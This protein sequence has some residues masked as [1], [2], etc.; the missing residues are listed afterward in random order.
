MAD[1]AANIGAAIDSARASTK[2]NSVPVQNAL[3]KVPAAE[4][5][6]IYE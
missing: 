3:W 2:T 6:V 4:R 5:E 1:G